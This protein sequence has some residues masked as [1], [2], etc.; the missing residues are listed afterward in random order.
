LA[1]LITETVTPYLYG[2][3]GWYSRT[4][5]T[6]EIGDEL[7]AQVVLHEISHMWFNDLLFTTRWID[8]GLAQEYAARAVAQLGGK[9]ATPNAVNVH[10]PAAI[11]LEAWDTVD[12]QAQNSQARE[13]FGYNASWLVVHRLTDEIG[14]DAVRRVIAAASKDAMPYLGTTN[15]KPR[16]A[17]ARGSGSSI[18]STRREGRRRP[19]RCSRS[20]SRRRA[21][22]RSRSARRRAPRTR[23]WYARARVGRRRSSCARR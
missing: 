5:N 15:P 9:P 7:D 22:R 8:E 13:T 6:I 17:R 12:L 23:S 18:T 4:D 21:T 10:A 20:T 16:A 2:Y 3:A 1:G 11:P 14:V 19:T